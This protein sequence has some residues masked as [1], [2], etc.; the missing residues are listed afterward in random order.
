MADAGRIVN[1]LTW[2]P[3]LVTYL[4]KNGSVACMSFLCCHIAQ[5]LLFISI[6]F[7]NEGLLVAF[8]G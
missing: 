2:N 7:R 4:S 8:S 5:V 1:K 6:V 3:K